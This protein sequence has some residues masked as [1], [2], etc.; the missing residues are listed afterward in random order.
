MKSES[1]NVELGYAGWPKSL[2]EIEQHWLVDAVRAVLTRY[3]KPL[4]LYLIVDAV[5][6]LPDA[7]EKAPVFS[8][9]VLNDWRYCAVERACRVVA[10]EVFQLKGGV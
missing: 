2:P 9:A 5:G 1:W 4:P 3:A 6:R 8:K 10:D 7:R